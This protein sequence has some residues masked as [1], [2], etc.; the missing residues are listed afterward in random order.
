MPT[1]RELPIVITA[2]NDT[3]PG[4]NAAGQDI[5]KLAE[6]ANRAG[7]G[8]GSGSGGGASGISNKTRLMLEK[9]SGDTDKSLREMASEV[10]STTRLIKQGGGAFLAVS[11]ATKVFD[12]VAK[13]IEEYR[14]NV[15][16]GMAPLKAFAQ[17]FADNIPVIG[18]LAK[19]I[20][21]LNTAIRHATQGESAEEIIEKQKAN[22][23]EN[24]ELRQKMQD[25]KNRRQG[26]I[27]GRANEASQQARD[28]LRLSGLTGDDREVMEARIAREKKLREADAIRQSAGGLG[29]T[30]DQDKVKGQAALVRQAAEAEFQDKLN[31]I[32]KEGEEKRFAADI[33]FRERAADVE[34]EFTQRNLEAQGKF[35]ESR[36]DAINQQYDKEIAAIQKKQGEKDFTEEQA[37]REAAL[38][39][40]VRDAAIAAANDPD[41]EE[42]RRVRER[43]K[44]DQE[45]Q[46]QVREHALDVDRNLHSARMDMLKAAAA[47]GDKGLEREEKKQ[48]IL[49]RQAEKLREIDTLMQK[50]GTT[51]AEKAKLRQS[52]DAVRASSAIEMLELLKPQQARFSTAEESRFGTGA[53]ASLRER[54][55]NRKDPTI[56][57]IKEILKQ[58]AQPDQYLGKIWD[59]F[60]A[61]YPQIAAAMGANSP[62]T[63]FRSPNV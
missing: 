24:R 44:Q 48:E 55:A 6:E 4:V 40:K 35:V 32:H 47:S 15:K 52:Q 41:S 51:E 9:S 26:E 63:L 61:K 49:E 57:Q 2:R 3:G 42:N 28:E 18:D 23:Q 25:E 54:I 36:V 60:V 62:T 5:R 17:S 22:D 1:A 50:P 46:Q 13:T 19:S 8:G 27:F 39:A 31:K 14:A 20:A 43:Q 11:L 34:H 33:E 45:K 53:T 12:G 30:E 59:T 10:R 37:G 58:M 29:R 7:G 16:S 56:D 21:A 38:A